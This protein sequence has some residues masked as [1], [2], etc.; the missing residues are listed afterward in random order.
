MARTHQSQKSPAQERASK[1]EPKSIAGGEDNAFRV[2][3]LTAPEPERSAL[4]DEGTADGQRSADAAPL[5]ETDPPPTDSDG[6]PGLRSPPPMGPVWPTLEKDQL[7]LAVELISSADLLKGE[8]SFVPR[9][10]RVEQ[11][12]TQ[13]ELLTTY[14]K[15]ADDKAAD[16]ARAFTP[17]ERA[18]WVAAHPGASGRS[19]LDAPPMLIQH[20]NG[21]TGETTRSDS[22]VSLAPATPELDPE[23][24]VEVF[25]RDARAMRM[26]PSDIVGFY[27]ADTSTA[28]LW[29]D[30]P[31]TAV[32]EVT[33]STASPA[34]QGAAPYLLDE[35]ATRYFTDLVFAGKDPDDRSDDRSFYDASGSAL[36]SSGESAGDGAEVEALQRLKALLVSG[37]LTEPTL[38]AAYVSGDPEAL[39]AVLDVWNGP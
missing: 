14:G 11:V 5:G 39:Q 27:W 36:P 33:H 24:F 38:R 25:V 17:P 15:L 2:S 37:R 4:L 18:A 9:A 8:P 23:A 26:L 21:I 32:H 31:N 7:Q 35:G 6:T 16:L 22:P 29:D 19:L 30:S 20:T 12:P 3:G 13:K 1:P 34:W 28:Y 10:S